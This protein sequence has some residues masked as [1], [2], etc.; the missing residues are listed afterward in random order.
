MHCLRLLWCSSFAS[1]NGPDRL[2]GNYA[3]SQILNANSLQYRT[4]LSSDD[5]FRF[6][7]LTLCE[8]FADTQ[9]RNEPS[10]K[11]RSKFLCHKV[12]VL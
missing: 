10:T 8:C 7:A 4:Q 6:A 12:I 3:F 11:R 2:V 1:T 5:P 9:N